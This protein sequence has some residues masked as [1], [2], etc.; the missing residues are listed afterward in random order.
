MK[1]T[2]AGVAGENAESQTTALPVGTEEEV[3]DLAQIML[4]GLDRDAVL[5]G[6]RGSGGEPGFTGS[7]RR[8]AVFQPWAWRRNGYAVTDT[9]VVIRRGR[10]ARVVSLVPHARVQSLSVAQGPLDR[11][12]DVSSVHLDLTSGPVSGVVVHLATDEAQRLLVEQSS[13]S[14][15]ARKSLRRPLPWEVQGRS[16]PTATVTEGSTHS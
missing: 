15:L 8:S 16:A 4:P 6:M 9:A 2:I 10:L 3:L 5:V 7:S 14:A 12:R 1:V 11:W 13:R